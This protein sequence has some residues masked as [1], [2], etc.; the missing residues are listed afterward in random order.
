MHVHSTTYRELSLTDIERI[1]DREFE[2]QQLA[3]A[4]TGDRLARFTDEE[5]FNG[6]ARL[7]GQARVQQCRKCPALSYHRTCDDCRAKARRTVDARR[8]K[9]D[10]AEARRYAR[11]AA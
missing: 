10:K 1:E 2:R 3:R 11:R 7:F 6:L 8:K 5:L 4:A 9:S